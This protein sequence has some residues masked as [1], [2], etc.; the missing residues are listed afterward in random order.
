MGGIEGQRDEWMDGWTGNKAP[1][2]WAYFSLLMGSERKKSLFLFGGD[3]SCLVYL[4]LSA[5]NGWEC[6]LLD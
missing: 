3:R 1:L 4:Y 6:W 5:E 2:V